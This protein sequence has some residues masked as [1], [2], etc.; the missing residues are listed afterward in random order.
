MSRNPA[1]EALFKEWLET[2]RGIFFKVTQSFART[3]TDAAELQQEILLQLW[4]SVPAYSGKAKASTWIYRFCLT[5]ALAGRRNGDR[6]KAK[7]ER[8]TDVRP[9]P[10]NP[11]S[12]AD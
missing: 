12:P 5:A 4:N 6:R 9:R 2:H 10:A 3:A 1:D 7:I 11:A 8:E